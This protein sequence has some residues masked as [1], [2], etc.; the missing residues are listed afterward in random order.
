ML[1]AG[2][3]Y[4]GHQSSCQLRFGFP[5]N[6]VAPDGVY[7]SVF[8]LYMARRQLFTTLLGGPSRTTTAAVPLPLP[9]GPP[10]AEH[11]KHTMPSRQTSP[12][13]PGIELCEHSQGW[14]PSP[15]AASNFQ[16]IL[17]SSL[18]AKRLY[19][20]SA[21]HNGYNLVPLNRI[22]NLAESQPE[23]ETVSLLV[24]DLISKSHPA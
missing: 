11:P 6:T 10:A 15:E 22:D 12:N 24:Q 7:D 16:N 19:T 21:F 3:G 4:K 18:S 8:C 1:G 2:N 17:N 13:A 5:S 14:L 20:S 23:I 9:G